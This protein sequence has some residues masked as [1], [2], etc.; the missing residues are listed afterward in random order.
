LSH[1]V[2]SSLILVA[3]ADPDI[4]YLIRRLLEHAGYQVLEASNGHECLQLYAQEKPALLL[5]DVMI[6]IMNG[7]ETYTRFQAL[8]TA[9]FPPVIVLTGSHDG[10]VLEQLHQLG[11]RFYL[12]KPF[13]VTAF[14]T[15][16]RRL[17]EI[18][19]ASMPDSTVTPSTISHLI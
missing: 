15:Y 10:E 7:L 9:S 17:L 13:R 2:G 1:R 12:T 8:L 11:V 19:P 4:R 3:D 18:Q 5:V 6:L 14:L 16:V